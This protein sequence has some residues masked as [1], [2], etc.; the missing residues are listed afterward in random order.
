M[1]RLLMP[2]LLSTFLLA[3]SGYAQTGPKSSL[4]GAPFTPDAVIVTDRSAV[5]E[6]AGA[7]REAAAQAGGT[8]QKSE[9]VVWPESRDDLAEQFQE[10]LKALGY[11]LT[12]L[13]EAD[14]EDGYVA[15]FR[16]AGTGKTPLAGLWVDDGDGVVLGWCTLNT[17]A[18]PRASA[19]APAPR[20]AAAPA[21]TAQAS[22][23]QPGKYGCTETQ[24]RLVNGSWQFEFQARGAIQLQ[25]DGR[26]V[27]PFGVTGRYTLN[28]GRTAATFSGGALG[29]GTATP[30]EGEVGRLRVTIPTA[31]GERRWTC[32]RM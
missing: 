30:I 16:L 1:T 24:P 23:L 15:A 10:G 25:P 28:T 14:D 6:F 22:A 19:L 3:A 11:S 26:Y 2:T 21:P 7:L 27:D 31:S 9:Y 18:A 8:C 4:V 17:A 13:D 5:N 29:G 12:L 20:P 32:G